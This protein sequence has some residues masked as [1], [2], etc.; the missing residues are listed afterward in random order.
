MYETY[1]RQ[2]LPDREYRE[3][4]GS[5]L[6]VFNSNNAFIVENILRNDTSGLRNWY[7]LIDQESGKLK[8]HVQET[9]T[10]KYGDE[11]EQLFSELINK[12]NRIVH[13]YQITDKDNKQKLATKERSRKGGRQ[14]VIT[15]EYLLK[16]IKENEKLSDLL[17]R[18]RRSMGKQ[19]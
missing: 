19:E 15:E 17:E 6:C 16:F 14:F 3:L 5:A 10:L 7:D 1:T 13:S 2:A 4:L 18:A 11:I 9:I 12:R 8:D